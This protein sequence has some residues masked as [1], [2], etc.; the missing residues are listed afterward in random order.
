MK[1][2]KL[3]GICAAAAVF[4]ASMPASLAVDAATLYIADYENGALKSLEI[5][6]DYVYTT[7]DAVRE[8]AELSGDMCAFVW[9]DTMQPLTGVITA[10]EETTPTVEPSVSPTPTTS[11]SATAAPT[12]TPAEGIEEAYSFVFGGA[13]DGAISVMA[14]TAYSE[15]ENGLT[16]GLI[17]IDESSVIDDYRFDGFYDD[18]LTYAKTDSVN[19]TSFVTAD[20]SGY[21]EETLATFGDGVIP[22]RFA[23]AAEPHRYYTVTATVVN[24]SESESTEISLFSENRYLQLFNYT[25]AAGETVTKTWNV[26]LE[27]QYYSATGAYTDEAINVAVAGEYA[28]LVSVEVKKHTDMG[29]TIW[30]MT[31]STGDNSAANLPYFGLRGKCGVG[32]ALTKYL[33]PDIAVNNQGEGGLTSSDSNHLNNA[34]KYIQ[35]GDCLYVQYGFNGETTSSLTANL[36]KYYNA[37][38]EAGA[39]LIVVS[40]TERQNS[41]FWDSS[42]CTWTASNSSIADAGRAYVESMIEAGADDI[43]FVDLNTAMNEWMNEESTNIMEQRQRLGFDDTTPSKQAMNYYFGYDRDSGVDSVH[44]NDAGADNAAYLVASEMVASIAEGGVQGVVLSELLENAPESEAYT[45]SDEIVTKGWVPNDS[46]PYPL[47]ND[48]TYEYPTIVKSAEIT[49]GA[50]VSM[51]VMAQGNMQYYALGAVDIL[52]SNGNVLRTAY[53]VSTDVN[54]LIDHIDNTECSYGEIYTMYFDTSETAIAEGETVRFYTLALPSGADE[55]LDEMYSSYYVPDDIDTVLLSEDFADGIDAW[56]T[57]GSASSETSYEEK[58]GYNAVKLTENGSGTYNAYR[59]FDGNAEADN[60]IIKLHFMINCSYGTFTVKLTPDTKASSYVNGVKL[61][62][63]TDSTVTAADGTEIGQIKTGKWTDIDCVLNLIDGTESISIAG[64]TPVTAAIDE[65]TSESASDVS[66]ILPLRGFVVAYV[67]TGST[68]PSYSFETYLTDISVT[69]LAC[70]I[71]AYTVTAAAYDGCESYG[72]VSGGG[73]YIINDEVTITAK[74][75][76][77]YEFVGWFDESDNEVSGKS[78]YSFRVRGDKTLYAKFEEDVYDPNVTKWSFSAFAGDDE[79]AATSAYDCD[80]NGLTIH[81]NSGDSITEEGLYWSAPGGTKSD[82]TTTVTNNRYI[83][84]TPEKSGT[85]S[86]TFAGS[87][88]STKNNP[89]IY[90]SCGDSLACTTKDANS[91][92][93]EANQSYDNT[94]GDHKFATAEFELTAGQH[95]YI[96]AYY[97]GQSGAD[98]TISAISYDT[99]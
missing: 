31:D 60:G 72:T 56:S 15:Q 47:P 70:E 94:E 48:V 86:I 33:N 52:D 44:I 76:D 77:G 42:T 32:Q 24:T 13:A 45:I 69:S 36:P 8:Y 83:E 19:G 18:V 51:T 1:L 2:K 62:N 65:L 81:I 38:H 68:I 97:Y 46:Y 85:L 5:V 87:V 92:Q 71:P 84:F 14:D 58:D 40:T 53:T 29:K 11:P 41:S 82:G 6:A 99:N 4:A 63:F 49:D 67:S 57:A 26:N 23:M 90:V 66:S 21:D 98:F 20:Y 50:A 25:L 27:G 30:L 55:P 59:R 89:R 54:P 64:G 93:L 78:S 12:S 96:W 75:A 88:L 16:Y 39:K 61:I 95:Y 80:Y 17:D 74:A 79:V 73:E 10:D 34:L 37:A 7:D 3:T 28:G 35:E 91:S 9:D 22:V 43:A